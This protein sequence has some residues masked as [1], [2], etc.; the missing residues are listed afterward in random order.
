MSKI[1]LVY[2]FLFILIN[3]HNNIMIIVNQ[4]LQNEVISY[5]LVG[6]ITSKEHAHSVKNIFLIAW[7]ITYLS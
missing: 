2:I 4:L 5:F 3:T 7:K 6:H 1:I